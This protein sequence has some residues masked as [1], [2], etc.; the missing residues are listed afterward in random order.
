MPLNGNAHAPGNPSAAKRPGHPASP[1]QLEAAK[2]NFALMQVMGAQ[3]SLTHY[4]FPY[5]ELWQ[6]EALEEALRN[7]VAQIRQEIENGKTKK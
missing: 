5:L 7:A 2:V 1:K 4:A 6:R 3:T